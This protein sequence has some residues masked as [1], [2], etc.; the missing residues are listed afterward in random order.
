VVHLGVLVAPP[1][2]DSATSSSFFIRARVES[3]LPLVLPPPSPAPPP[4][5][6]PPRDIAVIPGT[7][8]HSSTSRP[9]VSTF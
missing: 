9:N 1:S 6:P 3:K 8:L 7:D 2:S 4:P 5:A